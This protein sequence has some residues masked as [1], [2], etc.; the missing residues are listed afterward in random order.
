MMLDILRK[1]SNKVV[2]FFISLLLIAL[3]NFSF[4]NV[5]AVEENLDNEGG[6][7]TTSIDEERNSKE[8]KENN[9]D[10]NA[11]TNI[12][13]TKV[14]GVTYK[15][16]EDKLSYLPFVRYAADR[17]LIDKEV[18]GLGTM[19]SA[20]SIEV[21]SPMKGLQVL[22]ANDTVRV[23]SNMEYGVIFATN[24]VIIEG[25][26]DK[27]VIVFAGK[28]LTISENAVLND[29]LICYSDTLVVEGKVKGSI[30]GATE[31][32]TINGSIAKDLRIQV[33]NLEIENSENISENVYVETYNKELNIKDK[34]PNANVKYISTEK[35]AI[36]Y[37][38]IMNAI[39]TCLLFT[40]VYVIVNRKT[41]G[42]VFNVAIKKTTNNFLFVILSGTIMII[43]MPAVIIL[44]IILSLFGLHSLAVPALLVYGFGVL[45]VGLLSSLIVGSLIANYMSKNYFNDKSTSANA[46]G[47]FFVF[48]SLYVLA[49]LPY[50]GAYVTMALV[51]V[52]IGV[53]MAYIF[54]KETK[55]EV[56][57]NK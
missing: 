39:I 48:V 42:K 50:I 15:V 32:A 53:V 35:K 44:L 51:I 28:N 2:V 21:N 31:N 23:N 12:F 19:F 34:Y 8:N 26:F 49:K 57:E 38:V 29:D 5:K 7:S 9:I 43:V 10:T 45:V 56:T 17:I 41:K 27:P 16:S 4:N 18:S 37:D 24:N 46:L 11:V 47:T 54:K 33:T 52:A 6:I 14:S 40:L 55:K 25:T 36:S 3:V 20:N 13:D 22:F 1:K 30:L